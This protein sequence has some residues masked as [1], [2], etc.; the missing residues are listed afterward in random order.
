MQSRYFDAYEGW[1]RDPEGFWRAAAEAIHW[2]KPPDK[3]FDKDQGVYGHWFPGGETNTCYNC[4]DRHVEAGRG[5]QR[6]FIY[7]SVMTGT[8]KTFTYS[9]VLIEV[10]A[11][12]AVLRKHGV[13]KGDRVIIYMPMVPE[14][15]FSMLACARLG[16]IHSVVFG[17]FAAQ[18]LA[19]R[20]DDSKAK[21][22][23]SA[24]CGLEPGRVVAYKPLLDQAI[25][26]AK[27]KPDYCLLLQR[28]QLH[29]P[30]RYEHGDR[31][32]AEAVKWKR[33]AAPKC[34]AWR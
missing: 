29:A 32:F 21:V 18:E 27:T 16:A 23:I 24:S 25:D 2:F 26:M 6:A 19:A 7:D 17:G 8:Q 34:P 31:D 10:Q 13:A 11:I 22:I 20:L 4:L 30:L 1:Q 5:G 14:A 12:A 15:V 3:I 9:E 33:S 28:D